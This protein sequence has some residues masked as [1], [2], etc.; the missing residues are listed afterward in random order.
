[1]AMKVLVAGATGVIGT[2][3]LPQLRDA[4]YEVFGT[5][6]ATSKVDR[7]RAAGAVPIVVDVFRTEALVRAVAE[8]QPE[9]VIHQLT[10]LPPGLDPS[11]MPEALVRNARIRSEGTRSLVQASLASGVRRFIAQ[12][13]AWAYAPGGEPHRE[14]DALDLASEGSRAITVQGVVELERWTLSSRALEGVVLRYGQLYGPGAS[15]SNAEGSAPVHVDA[16]A[17]AAVLAIA[18]GAPG[19]Y[20]IA[21]ETEYVSSAEARRELGWNPDYRHPG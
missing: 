15:R 2:R 10:D 11:R 16:A 21:E 5:T 6:R 8:V 7:L 18:R 4:G 14:Q 19:L 13:I 1:M 9:I 20:N 12:S 3:L 17:Q